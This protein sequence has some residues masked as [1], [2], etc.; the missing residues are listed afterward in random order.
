MAAYIC[1][2][3]ITSIKDV[4]MTE[5]AMMEE[6]LQESLWHESPDAPPY[7]PLSPLPSDAV[8]IL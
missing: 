2:K 7:S 6:A 4:L 8:N 5:E 3:F 1:N